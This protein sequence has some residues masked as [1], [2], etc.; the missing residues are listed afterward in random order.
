MTN[1]VSQ[2]ASSFDLDPVQVGKPVSSGGLSRWAEELAFLLG[3]NVH[4]IAEV[5]LPKRIAPRTPSLARRSYSASIRA[6][7]AARALGRYPV[8]EWAK[9]RRTMERWIAKRRGT[10]G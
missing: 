1:P 8:R 4:K 9:V 6:D 5:T 2:C 7:D 3:H 10:N